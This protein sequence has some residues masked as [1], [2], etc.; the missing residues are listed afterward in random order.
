MN[1]LDLKIKLARWIKGASP[2]Y[3]TGNAGTF[4]AG[5]IAVA[6]NGG[7]PISQNF[8]LSK[9]ATMVLFATKIA[10]DAPEVASA[11]YDATSDTILLRSWAA[12][13][14]VM[15][16]DTTGVT[17]TLTLAA[18]S[19]PYLEMDQSP[20]PPR[21]GQPYIAGKLRTVDVIGQDYIHAP[22]NAGIVLIIGN[23]EFILYLQAYGATALQ[24][25]S[26]LRSSLEMPTVQQFLSSGAVVF[27]EDVGGVQDISTLIDSQNEKR[28]SLDIRFRTN[29]LVTDNPGYIGELIATETIHGPD[30][31]TITLDTLTI[32]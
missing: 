30:G 14:L 21:P 32:S 23:R 3:L 29:E 13:T 17:G 1:I 31:I 16:P 19:T 6:I 22:N 10:E 11:I 26:D 25:L 4:T 5:A 20:T 18:S 8:S 7:A 15:V 12:T 27:V 24:L 9:S 2:F 28:A